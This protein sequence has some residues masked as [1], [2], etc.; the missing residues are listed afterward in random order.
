MHPAVQ[1]HD[2]R[3][4]LAA[5]RQGI[6]EPTRQRAQRKR[7]VAGIQIRGE[8][9]R[10]QAVVEGR[11]PGGR[12]ES[13][14]E[15]VDGPDVDRELDRDAQLG[16]APRWPARARDEVPR[17]V[18]LPAQLSRRG[19]VQSVRLDARPRVRRRSQAD[20]VRPERRGLRVA[21]PADVLQEH[22]HAAAISRG[23][24]SANGPDEF[25]CSLAWPRPVGLREGRI[26]ARVSVVPNL[27]AAY[28]FFG[29]SS[30]NPLSVMQVERARRNAR[31]DRRSLRPRLAVA[32][33]S[34]LIAARRFRDD[35]CARNAR[36]A[37]LLAPFPWAE[38]AGRVGDPVDRRAS[39]CGHEPAA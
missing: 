25:V 26:L 5:L 2:E 14:V 34:A 8:L 18:L 3:N 20:Q 16:E 35:Q 33:Q 21:V 10:E 17:G 23:E 9:V 38:R 19:E 27:V 36:L 22:A 12:L 28:S 39:L 37:S 11:F 32:A 24:S 29:P 6:Q 1:L 7:G 30:T 4:R 15:G 13:E 31:A